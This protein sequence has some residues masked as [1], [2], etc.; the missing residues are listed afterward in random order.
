MPARNL[1]SL[2]AWD[3]DTGALNV[4]IETTKGSRTKL[5][6]LPNEQLFVLKK[7]L[8]RGT[9]FP[10][11]FGFIPST[12]GDDGDPLDVL[13]LLA[14]A[15][16]A[17][18]KI[19]ARLIGVIEAEQA[20]KG[21]VKRNDRLI[22]VADCCDEHAHLQSMKDLDEYLIQEIEH[23]FVFYQELSQKSIE[24]LGHHGPRRAHKLVEEGIKKCQKTL[25]NGGASEE[26]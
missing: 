6:Y 24:I 22:A 5:K 18:C 26:P 13:M 9:V 23:F 2:P 12:L 11:D 7:M 3:A 19:S 25:E 14:E 8:P 4:I 10:F 21:T 1:Q 15:V 17:G 16:P 20:E